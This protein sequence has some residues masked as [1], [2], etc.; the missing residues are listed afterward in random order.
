MWLERVHLLADPDPADARQHDVEL[1]LRE[2]AVPRRCL[3]RAQQPQ[4][5][6][7]RLAAELFGEVGVL[8]AHLIGGAPVGIGGMEHHW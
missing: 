7:E 5:R 6:G 4:P 3:A 2:V 1:G 8:H